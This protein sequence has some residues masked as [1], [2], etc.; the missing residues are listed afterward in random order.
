MTKEAL[1]NELANNTWVKIRQSEVDGVGVFAIRDIPAGC[2][3][4]FSK[5]MGEWVSVPF[6][7]VEALPAHAKDLIENYCLYDEENY[8]IPAQGFKA[9][10]L[11]L[12]LNHSDTPNIFSI[13][14]G[15]YF[16]TVR[17]IKKGEEL[18]LDYATIVD[19]EL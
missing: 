13:N 18:F 6:S 19:P 17:P 10:D 8:F 7:E 5:E 2:R 4:V 12:L 14:D 11:S 16:E 15:E 9:I 1:L 3:D